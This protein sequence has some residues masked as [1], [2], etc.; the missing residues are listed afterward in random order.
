MKILVLLALAACLLTHTY[1]VLGVDV[2]QLFQTSTYQCMKTNGYSFAIIRGYCSFGGVDANAVH[3][4][5]NAK[6]AGLAT[7]IYMFPCRGKNATLQ[8]NQLIDYLNSMMEIK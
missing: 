5:N 7:D 1:C 4:L 2:S 6:A 8:V 3:N